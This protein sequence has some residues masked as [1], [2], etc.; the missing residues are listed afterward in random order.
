MQL[1]TARPRQ[2]RRR[3]GLVLLS[4][5]LLIAI[6]A[7]GL[8][9]RRRSLPA[10][11]SDPARLDLLRAAL[12]AFNARDYD[13]ATATLDRRSG[14]A[15]PTA[16]DWMLR[17]RIARAQDR[18]ED[19]LGYLERIPDSSAIASKARLFAG[20]ILIGR[21]QA[22]LAE[23]AFLRSLEL[24]PSQIQPYRELIS[25]YTFQQRK[26]ECDALFRELTRFAKLDNVLAF[27]WSQNECGLLDP[28]EAIGI[29]RECVEAD[30]EDRVSR[31]A[32]ARTSLSTHAHQ[33]VQ[34]ALA[35]LSRDDPDVRAILIEDALDRAEI[36][37]AEGL[38]KDIA[39]ESPLVALARA[40]LA[41]ARADLRAAANAFRVVLRDDPSCPDAIRGL[42]LVLRRLGDPEAD[43]F[44]RTS[45][46]QDELKRSIH[47]SIQADQ[48][49]PM[50]HLKLGMLC[51]SLDLNEQAR[52]WFRLVLASDPSNTK[53][54]EALVR[55]AERP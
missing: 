36:E 4:L 15:R 32:L 13:L 52:A 21:H 20:Q 3:T 51:E 29:L 2:G 17:A 33:D 35:P 27:A 26:K 25:I 34:W 19:A 54:R 41:L 39:G 43:S 47:A 44:L 24:E 16:L 48:T 31:L 18:N 38:A 14:V 42:G 53:A 46:R 9:Q 45:A 40:K 37:E 10:G 49:D 1:D 11:E 23:R 6:L 50:L 8:V 22:R 28:K 7:Y 12:E 55:L 30:P 5:P